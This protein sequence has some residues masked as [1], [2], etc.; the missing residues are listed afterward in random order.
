MASAKGVGGRG[1]WTLAVNARRLLADDQELEPLP[2]TSP[3]TPSSTTSFA[4]L[5]VNPP[6]FL[7]IPP[8]SPPLDDDAHSDLD[9]NDHDA[10]SSEDEDNYTTIFANTAYADGTPHQY[11]LNNEDVVPL[12][13]RA[14]LKAMTSPR[15]GERPTAKE[16]LAILDNMLLA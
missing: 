12:E 6:P 14:L 1:S 2:L 15:E 9:S 4:Q 5:S 8:P 13:V 16:V 7:I 3:G 10:E 11:F